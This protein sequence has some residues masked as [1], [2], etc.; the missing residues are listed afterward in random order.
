[1]VLPCNIVFSLETIT[2]F[3][4]DTICEDDM[5]NKWIHNASSVTKIFTMQERRSG[6]G[7]RTYYD[8]PVQ[9]MNSGMRKF[10]YRKIQTNIGKGRSPPCPTPS[11]VPLHTHKATSW[12]MSQLYGSRDLIISYNSIRSFRQKKNPA[13]RRYLCLWI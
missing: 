13:Y 4:F 12:I 1:M 7:Q 11:D 6:G 2:T 8:F 5:K 9:F 3:F 10:Y